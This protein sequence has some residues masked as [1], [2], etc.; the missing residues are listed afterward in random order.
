MRFALPSRSLVSQL[1][2]HAAASFSRCGW[3][4]LSHE[5]DGV[6]DIDNQLSKHSKRSE[7][8]VKDLNK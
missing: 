4:A 8:K 5:V 3:L 6:F 7:T 2:N 1:F